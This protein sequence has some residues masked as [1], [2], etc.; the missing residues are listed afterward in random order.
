MDDP[1]TA[2]FDTGFDC[3][4]GF[5]LIQAEHALSLVSASLQPPS[6]P[7]SPAHHHQA[8]VRSPALTLFYRRRGNRPSP[9]LS[10]FL[11]NRAGA[12]AAY[13]R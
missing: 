7:P 13:A 4:T 9:P 10:A 2:G 12:G 1:A 11:A 8:E 5:G 6:A 3:R